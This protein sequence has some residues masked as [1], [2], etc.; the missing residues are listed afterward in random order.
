VLGCRLHLVRARTCARHQNPAATSAKSPSNRIPACGGQKEF[1]PSRVRDHW[2]LRSSCRDWAR[3]LRHWR[4]FSTCGRRDS[5][6]STRSALFFGPE[7][8]WGWDM[9]LAARSNEL[10]NMLFI[11]VVVWEFWLAGH[12]A[13]TS[14]ISSLRGS[15]FCASC[16]SAGITADELKRKIDAGEELVIVD[17]RHSVDFEADPHTIPGAFRMDAKDLEV[18]DDRLP[19]GPRRHPLLYLTKRGH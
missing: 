17:L 13:D 9:S 18:K 12:W 14:G 10:P 19:R 8:M 6:Y 7:L 3:W 16:A 1:S 5:C 2:C 15:D 4:A 11:W